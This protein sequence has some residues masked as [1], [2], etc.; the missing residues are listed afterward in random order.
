MGNYFANFGES[1]KGKHGLPTLLRSCPE[2]VRTGISIW[3][4]GAIYGSVSNNQVLILTHTDEL[5]AL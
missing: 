3:H 5:F 4:P 2:S 1:N